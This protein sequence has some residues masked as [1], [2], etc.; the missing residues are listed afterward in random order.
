LRSH[1][2]PTPPTIDVGV[3]GS[4][5]TEIFVCSIIAIALQFGHVT[6]TPFRVTTLSAVACARCSRRHARQKVWVQG[7]LT[8]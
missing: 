5:D 2:L 8:G 1:R 6:R 3:A 7:R 4:L